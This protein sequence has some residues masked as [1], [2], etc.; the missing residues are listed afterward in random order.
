MYT[1]FMDTSQLHNSYNYLV[2]K[3]LF[4]GPP[5][6]ITTPNGASEKK[7]LTVRLEGEKAVW[8]SSSEERNVELDDHV[9]TGT[10]EYWK[11]GG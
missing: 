6:H 4:I 10:T 3:S 7:K 11:Q 9:D 8:Q 2:W 1:I 5:I